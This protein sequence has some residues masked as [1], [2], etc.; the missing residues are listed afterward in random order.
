M[1]VGILGSGNVGR[2]LGTALID[3]GEDVTLGTRSPEA[4]GAETPLGKWLADTGGQGRAASFPDTAAHGEIVINATAGTAS[5]DALALAG[6]G[7]LRGKIL[8]DAANPLDFSG[9]MPPVLSVSNR[10]SLGEQIQRALPDVR[11]VKALNTVTARLM[12]DPA[13]LAGGDHHLFICGDDA[14]AKQE[15]SE[16]LGR[17]FGW[18]HIIDVGDITCARGTEML[19]P[20]WIRLYAALGT[21]IFNFKVVS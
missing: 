6:R 12:V 8:I 16:L 2:T 15:V 13:Q 4:A 18:R 1:K 17:W 5:L 7:N 20:L 10:D 11:V 21:P 9:G 14:A 3:R 19:L